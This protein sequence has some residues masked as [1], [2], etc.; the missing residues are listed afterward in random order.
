MLPLVALGR[1]QSHTQI[2][3]L[4][5]LQTRNQEGTGTDLWV[6]TLSPMDWWKNR[7]IKCWRWCLILV[8]MALTIAIVPVL[9]WWF[10]ETDTLEMYQPPSSPPV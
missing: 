4:E 6:I 7:R 3:T 10:N 8:G 2:H 1:A 9:V 5:R